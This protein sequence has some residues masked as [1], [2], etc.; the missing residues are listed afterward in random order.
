MILTNPSIRD[1]LCLQI[2]QAHCPQTI[3]VVLLFAV[4]IIHKALPTHSLLERTMS[5][6]R[7]KHTGPQKIIAENM[8]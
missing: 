2:L 7:T 6:T 4:K 3:K 5:F 8:T 1:T